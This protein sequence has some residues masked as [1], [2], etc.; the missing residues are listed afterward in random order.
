MDVVHSI[1]LE[2]PTHN[3]HNGCILLL[4]FL[5]EVIYSGVVVNTDVGIHLYSLV[6]SFTIMAILS[7]LED[8]VLNCSL[9]LSFT[10]VHGTFYVSPNLQN[11][12]IDFEESLFI[13]CS[14]TFKTANLFISKEIDWPMSTLRYFLVVCRYTAISNNSK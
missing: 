13:S 8:L 3:D 1:V 7:S 11:D 4:F 12:C 5:L 14:N 10:V 2:L 9:N 6:G